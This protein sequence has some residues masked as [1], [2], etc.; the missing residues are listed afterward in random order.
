VDVKSIIA[1][2]PQGDAVAGSRVM[3]VLEEPGGRAGSA[4]ERES[5][6]KNPSVTVGFE[7]EVS[8]RREGARKFGDGHWQG[9]Q[10]EQKHDA[11]PAQPQHGSLQDSRLF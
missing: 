9:V 10:A 5:D 7:A 8:L 1:L 11:N 6:V 3:V 4:L 2:A